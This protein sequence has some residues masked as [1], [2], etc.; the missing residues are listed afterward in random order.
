MYAYYHSVEPQPRSYLKDGVTQ[1]IG[2][3]HA[4]PGDGALYRTVHAVAINNTITPNQTTAAHVRFGFTS[5]VDDCVPVAG[6][7]PGTLGFSPSFVS[8]VP[9]KKFPYFAIGSYGTDY[10]GYMFG[11]RPINALTYYS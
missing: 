3:N 1:D 10:N 5:F 2:A 8:Q 7:D 4:D 6:F 9:V 11:E